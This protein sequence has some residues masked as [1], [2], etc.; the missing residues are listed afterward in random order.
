MQGVGKHFVL[1][2]STGLTCAFGT[3]VIDI[4]STK[5]LCN[6]CRVDCMLRRYIFYEN[7]VKMMRIA[8]FLLYM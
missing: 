3:F 2:L 8:I 4:F 7:L 1:L 5:S 6:F